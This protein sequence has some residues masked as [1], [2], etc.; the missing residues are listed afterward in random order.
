MKNVTSVMFFCN[1]VPQTMYRQ[2]R[3]L[4]LL[5]LIQI[6]NNYVV[7]HYLNVPMASV[8]TILMALLR[9]RS[10]AVLEIFFRF[11]N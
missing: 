9:K 10:H 6:R 8:K 4:H 7:F 3:D 1:L 5:D 11:K 2:M